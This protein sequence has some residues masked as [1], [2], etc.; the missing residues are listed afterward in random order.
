MANF[1]KE[2]GPKTTIWRE[3]ADGL[4]LVA[5]EPGLPYGTP[6]IGNVLRLPSYG[7]VRC[8]GVAHTGSGVNQSIVEI[9]LTVR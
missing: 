4:T 3:G 6:T 5:T 2:T 7:E 1:A 8:S 9:K